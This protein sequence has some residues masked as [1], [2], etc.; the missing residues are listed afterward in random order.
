MPIYSKDIIKSRAATTKVPSDNNGNTT[1]RWVKVAASTQ[2]LANFQKVSSIL[3]VSIIHDSAGTDVDAVSQYNFIITAQWTKANSASS[4][5]ANETYITA[6][7]IGKW[8]TS[9]TW[10]PS[11]YLL[12]TYNGI[13]SAE[14]W[15]RT[16]EAYSLAFATV[17]GGSD[18]TSSNY[19][20][21]SFEILSG[22][23]WAASVTSLGTDVTGVWASKELSNLKVA[24]LTVGSSA[25]VADLTVS[26]GDI[27]YGN[28]QNATIDIA[29]TAHNAAGKTLTITAGSP[30]AGTTNDI[31][32]GSI[33][34][35]AGA[36]KGQGA[37]GDIVFQTANAA[38][39][40]AS[41]INAHA[42][43]LTISD[44]LGATFAGIISGNGSG[45]TTLN[46]S[47]L[48]AGTINNARLPAAATTITSV[49]TLSALEV[50]TISI[51]ANAITSTADS[52]LAITAKVGQSL[53]LEELR[54]ADGVVTGATSITSTTFVGALTGNADTATS[55]TTATTA[56][57]ATNANITASSN[58]LRPVILGPVVTAG[59]TQ[60]TGQR[61]LAQDANTGIT[62]HTNTNTLTTTTFS[63]AL[64]GNASTASALAASVNIGGV[65]FDGSTSITPLKVNV[66]AQ[67][68]QD[69]IKYVHFGAH[70][71]GVDGGIQADTT[72]TWNPSSNKLHIGGSSTTKDTSAI[73][74][75][76]T[77]YVGID[78]NR[79]DMAFFGHNDHAADSGDYCL[80]QSS[81]GTSYLNAA[82]GANLYLRQ[83]NQDHIMMNGKI[84]IY[85]QID[86]NGNALY[87]ED[88]N[89]NIKADGH[90]YLDMDENDN[91][92]NNLYVRSGGDVVR[93]QVSENGKVS[94][95]SANAAGAALTVNGNSSGA[96]YSA[97]FK[98]D[99]NNVNRYGIDIYCGEDSGSGGT[100]GDGEV[101]NYF[102]FFHDGNGTE[103]GTVT[104]DGGAVSYNP[105]TGCHIAKLKN[106]K[107]L[108]SDEKPDISFGHVVVIHETDDT[109]PKQPEY[110]VEMSSKPKQK[111][112]FGVYWNKIYK[113]FEE[114]TERHQIFSLGDGSIWA[115]SEGGDIEIGD[116][117]CTSSVPG[118]VMKQDDDILRNYTVARATMAVKWDEEDSNKKLVPCTVHCG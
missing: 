37:G 84:H 70:S 18:G 4:V 22:Q 79:A 5:D 98:N 73:K 29:D 100:N 56:T 108:K 39:G 48:S 32:G 30:T 67:N 62:Y 83:H 60:T 15:I 101:D 46:A 20:S 57:N 40:A 117:L 63:G 88:N 115:C 99:G 26:G 42:T 76:N 87:W 16:S 53:G 1:G 6:E 10:D 95:H 82:D 2:A 78:P 13:S 14:I 85:K 43:A 55:A 114:E 113:A 31:A 59:A 44:D 19:S 75:G 96:G 51:N 34:I 7:P 24:D 28:G 8:S 112:I 106:G 69:A 97:I 9:N 103:L 64:S 111:S 47:N 23:S 93:F 35:K 86:M 52:L 77:A 38:G 61:A 65:A 33:T 27:L 50:D 104:G 89:A 80:L 54:I 12:L 81:D 21:P 45:I 116:F 49:G 92:S 94:I 110:V 71:S 72:F 107:P 74:F 109:M 58:A 102:I 36:G 105:F 3:L 25:Q 91:S 118:H 41:T 66:E 11:T 68:D 17:I 90:I